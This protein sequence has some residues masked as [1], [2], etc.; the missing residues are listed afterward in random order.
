[1]SPFHVFLLG[2]GAL[3]LLQFYWI[4]KVA[5]K[6]RVDRSVA[7]IATSASL[8]VLRLA[9]SLLVIIT[10]TT[11]A[12]ILVIWATQAIG[13][14]TPEAVGRAIE[15]IQG[16]R[17]SLLRVGSVWSAVAIVLLAGA[18]GFYAHR[19]A[20]RRM[21]G[22]FRRAVDSEIA[23]LQ[24][25]YQRGEWEDIPPTK[26]MKEVQE[27][28]SQLRALAAGLESSAMPEETKAERRRVYEAQEQTLVQH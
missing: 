15:T 5:F 3:A 7:S 14:A 13:G 28:L 6:L 16:W 1:M 23:R 19:S 24:Q 27:R 17:S 26:A 11:A 18:L 12:I 22:A 10:A 2:L 21:E 8:A 9:R 25:E 4:P 20:K